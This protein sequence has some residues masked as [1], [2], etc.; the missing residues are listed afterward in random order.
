MYCPNPECPHVQATGEPAEY[1]EGIDRCNDCGTGLVERKPEKVQRR[2][3]FDH[4]QS[5][6]EDEE[7]V[8]VIEVPG[9][10][11]SS[12]VTSLLQSAGIRFFI[13]GDFTAYSQLG[14]FNPTTSSA[15]LF[16]ESSRA[17]EARELLAAIEEEEDS[18]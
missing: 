18:S 3:D 15:L 8:P 16:V 13:K 2:S 1:R 14:T 12:F 17:S 4:N 5:E 6:I 9:A 7:F 10:A 11:I